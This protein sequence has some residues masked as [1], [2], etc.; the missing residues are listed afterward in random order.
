RHS[1]EQIIA[2]LKQGEAGVLTADLCR[3]HGVSEQTYHRWKAKFGG[4]RHCI[5][6]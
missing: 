3:Q 5:Q 6:D 2:I 4:W 1:E